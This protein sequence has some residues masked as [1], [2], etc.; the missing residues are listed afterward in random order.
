MKNSNAIINSDFGPIIINVNDTIIGRQICET[1][2]WA[3]DDINL[4]IQIIDFLLQNKQ[5]VVFY[6]VG[7]NIGTHSLAIG[8][9]FGEKIIIRAFEAQRQIFNM[10]CGTVALNG[11]S[12]IHCHNLAVSNENGGAIQIAL[13][14]Y[15]DTN[16]FGS[17]E[18]IPPLYS[19]NQS[20]TKN[21]FEIINT[22]TLDHFNEE[23]NFIK[24]DIEGMEDKAIM[25]AEKIFLNYR[26][27]CFVEFLKT[28]GGFLV[29]YFKELK[30]F[31]F[32]KN[33]DLI[34][35]PSE[36]NITIDGLNRVF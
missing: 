15:D 21:N 9:T 2:Y 11:L 28:D 19:D 17:I 8:K 24:M 7:S 23:V 33:M 20:I 3:K 31:G 25:G 14:S 35:I 6:D 26:P 34:A 18:L 5:S 4:I 30:Y 32:Q 22:V 10:L 29:N 12:N 13:P 27:I 36:C 1:G 16:N